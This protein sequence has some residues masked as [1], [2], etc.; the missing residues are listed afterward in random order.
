[1]AN[2]IINAIK[3]VVVNKVEDI[4]TAVRQMTNIIQAAILA[5]TLGLTTE[6]VIAVALD[7][8]KKYTSYGEFRIV[9]NSDDEFVNRIQAWREFG[10]GNL[11]KRLGF[12]TRFQ[13]VQ[14]WTK[15]I[16]RQSA[17]KLSS[18]IAGETLTIEHD[19][20]DAV[21][22][23]ADILTA[24]WFLFAK[25]GESWEEIVRQIVRHEYR[26][27]RQFLKLRERGG[28]GYVLLAYE[29][30]VSEV[31]YHGRV[32]ERDAWANQAREPEDQDPLD[33]VIDEIIAKFP[34]AF[35][36]RAA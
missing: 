7:E 34:K 29:T 6:Q 15:E 14:N 17:L 11:N 32:T 28:N 5:Q 26:H 3:N 30:D 13:N 8:A 20:K 24:I 4:K 23:Y 36:F 22:I 27:M 31:N 19:G 21:Y 1:M 18:Q 35:R 9:R 25:E 10:E 33:P 2:F 16:A 12:L